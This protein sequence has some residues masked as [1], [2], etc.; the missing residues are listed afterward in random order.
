MK[1]AKKIAVALLVVA[2][3]LL[4]FGEKASSFGWWK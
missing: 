1:T 3:T 2:C 4:V